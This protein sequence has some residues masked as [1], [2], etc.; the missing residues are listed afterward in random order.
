MTAK[1]VAFPGAVR[2]RSRELGFVD[3][4]A[5]VRF[6]LVVGLAL[7]ALFGVAIALVLLVL[8]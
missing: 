8:S 5:L 3:P 4:L 7:G 2:P 6:A 1:I